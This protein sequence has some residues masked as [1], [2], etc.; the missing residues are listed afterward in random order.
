MMLCIIADGHILPPYIILNHKTV[1]KNE[2]FP[3]NIIVCAHK[4]DG[5]LI[6]RMTGKK[7]SEKDTLMLGITH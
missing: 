4:M 6:W 5:Q 7:T 3:N 1:P 2:M